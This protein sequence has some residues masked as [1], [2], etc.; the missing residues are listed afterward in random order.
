MPAAA[1][2]TFHPV[3]PALLPALERFAATQGRFR[4]CGCMR[5]RMTSA[6][7]RRAGPAGRTAALEAAV[8]AG[9]P[10]GVLALEGREPVGWCSAAP[11]ESHRGLLRHRPLALGEEQPGVWSVTCFL[12][13]PRLR[14]TGLPPRLLRAALAYAR[15]LGARTVEGFPVEPGRSY[16][17]MGSPRTFRAAGFRDA[18]PPGA[19]RPTVRRKLRAGR[20]SR[21][22]PASRPTRR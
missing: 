6:D 2:V 12:V 19:T 9:A 20:R 18:T 14:G 3:T 22:S 15:S 1:R 10:V 8:R 5:W 17:F 11:R 13:A 4:W 7:F 16:R 21:A